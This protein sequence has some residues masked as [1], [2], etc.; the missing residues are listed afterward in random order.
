M[1]ACERTRP[2]FY[3]II[4]LLKLR[5]KPTPI[6]IPCFNDQYA[7]CK[8]KTGGYWRRCSRLF[9]CSKCGPFASLA[10]SDHPGKD[11]QT[12]FESKSVGWG[13]MQCNPCLFFHLRYDPPLPARRQFSEKSFSSIFYYRYH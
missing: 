5:K 12:T 4:V 9:L 13:Q 3:L 6:C 8:K 10:G 1:F 11:Q 7:G 2:I